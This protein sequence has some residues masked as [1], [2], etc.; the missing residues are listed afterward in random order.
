MAPS[1]VM[2]KGWHPSF[3]PAEGHEGPAKSPPVTCSGLVSCRRPASAWL[4]HS[5]QSY[6]FFSFFHFFSSHA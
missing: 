2:G 6:L 1:P 5:L 4:P 3:S